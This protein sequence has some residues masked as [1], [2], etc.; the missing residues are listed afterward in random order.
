MSD[1][2]ET[3]FCELRKK[4]VVNS[5]DGKRLGRIIDLIISLEPNCVQGIVVPYGKFNLFSK[6]QSVFIPFSCINKI[7]ADVI[8]VDIISDADGNLLCKT[9][10]D[11]NC[12][13]ECEHGHHEPHKPDKLPDCDRRCEKCMMYD[14]EHRWK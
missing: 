6:Q 13:C 11:E 12:D 7:G 1:V 10:S 3:S 14:C 4:E 2:C 9:K 8:L 5:S